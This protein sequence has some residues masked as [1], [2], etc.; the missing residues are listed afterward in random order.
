[1]DSHHPG[2]LEDP[3]G[4]GRVCEDAVEEEREEREMI[5]CLVVS[6]ISLFILFLCFLMQAWKKHPSIF[7]TD[8]EE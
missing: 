7:S 6:G 4:A 1:M 2:E 3:P 8:D 5:E